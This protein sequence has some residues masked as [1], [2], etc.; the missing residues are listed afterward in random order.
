MFPFGHGE[1]VGATNWVSQPSYQPVQCGNVINNAHQ[2]N[3][4]AS[5][6]F[7]WFIFYL[8][9][10]YCLFLSC[11]IHLPVL[12]MYEY[13]WWWIGWGSLEIGRW[14]TK[15]DG[16]GELN[17]NSMAIWLAIWENHVATLKWLT[18]LHTPP[19]PVCPSF[20]LHWFHS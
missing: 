2:S 6:H 4:I 16:Y 9:L 8:S 15:N 1:P 12:Y 5:Y 20:A 17:L 7:I 13:L 18:N 19:Y 3:P 10:S 14:T 11:P